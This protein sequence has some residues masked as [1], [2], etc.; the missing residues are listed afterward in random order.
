MSELGIYLALVVDKE[1][2][3]SLALEDVTA[4]WKNDNG[5][6]QRPGI[7]TAEVLGSMKARE[8]SLFY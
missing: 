1:R 3:I 6:G 4:K 8:K 5:R 7:T 2:L